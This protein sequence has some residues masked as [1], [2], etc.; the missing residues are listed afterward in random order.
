[1]KQV[2]NWNRPRISKFPPVRQIASQNRLSRPLGLSPRINSL[3][4]L[5]QSRNPLPV[6]LEKLLAIGATSQRW[7]RHRAAA[8]ASTSLT[9]L[10]RKKA[11]E[12]EA[13]GGGWGGR[14]ATASRGELLQ[15][16]RGSL[17]GRNCPAN[18]DLSR[19][20]LT[21]SVLDCFQQLDFS[22]RTG[23]SWGKCDV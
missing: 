18:F 7:R 3:H 6:L 22:V 14:S 16:S 20:L 11:W 21:T 9:R 8:S 12:A 13:R 4:I 1:M 19:P 23:P 17:F 2:N 10:Q 5:S 15:S